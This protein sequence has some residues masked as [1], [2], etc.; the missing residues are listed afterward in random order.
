[1][2]ISVTNNS[3]VDQKINCPLPAPLAVVNSNLNSSLRQRE[4]AQ[5]REGKSAKTQRNIALELIIAASTQQGQE[6]A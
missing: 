5:K 4:K 2:R 1:M 3:G 6:R